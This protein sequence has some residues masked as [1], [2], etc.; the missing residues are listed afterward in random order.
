MALYYGNSGDIRA[1][2]GNPSEIEYSANDLLRA[3]V[4][5][6]SVV[7][8]YLEKQYPDS[9]PFS[10]SG[11][12]PTLVTSITEDLSIYFLKRDKHRGPSPLLDSIKEEYWQ[13]S[14]DLLTSISNGDVSIPELD[15]T[16]G[17][18]IISKQSDYTPTFDEGAIEDSVI[19]PDKLDDISDAKD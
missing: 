6:T 10:T 17:D 12:V 1:A 2:L 4:K 7:N 3:R 15:S 11:D 18:D 16:A 8:S 5:A 9:I 14:I 19:D 13:K